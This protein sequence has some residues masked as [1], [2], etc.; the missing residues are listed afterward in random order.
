MYSWVS[1]FLEVGFNGARST[2]EGKLSS[3]T[4]LVDTKAVVEDMARL[5]HQAIPSARGA[6]RFFRLRRP[7]RHVIC[8]VTQSTCR[9]RSVVV[10][11]GE[12]D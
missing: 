1:P 10:L 5:T 7:N 6:N 8:D 12:A 3:L 4:H 11:G 9:N 2:M